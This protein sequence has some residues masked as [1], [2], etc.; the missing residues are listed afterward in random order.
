ML[1][2]RRLPL[3]CISLTPYACSHMYVHDTNKSIHIHILYII[4]IY[5]DTYTY[6]R[7]ICCFVY[8]WSGSG[9]EGESEKDRESQQEI[10]TQE[11][12]GIVTPVRW[13]QGCLSLLRDKQRRRVNELYSS[14]RSC[15][16]AWPQFHGR[17][18]R[19]NHVHAHELGLSGCVSTL[20]QLLSSS[21]S[22]TTT[23]TATTPTTTCTYYYYY[24]DYNHY[25]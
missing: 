15:A 2:C 14:V 1:F 6:I 12:Q 7:H 9:R 23:T 21:S 11:G 25:V 17:N 24:D 20:F 8:A 5:I 19:G 4:Y 16:A 22:S 10:P 13:Q 18:F 3:Q